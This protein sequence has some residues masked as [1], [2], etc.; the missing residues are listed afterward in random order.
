MTNNEGLDPRHVTFSQAQGYEAL[1]VPLA[2]GEISYEARLRLWD[3]LAN[4]A[5]LIPS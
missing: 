3:L 5:L 4:I 1:P 2:L